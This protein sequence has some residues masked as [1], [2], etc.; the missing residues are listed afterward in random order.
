MALIVHRL[1]IVS[2]SWKAP[3]ST[4]PS[5]NQLEAQ[6]KAHKTLTT[7]MVTTLWSSAKQAIP[8]RR[9]QWTTLNS[10]SQTSRSL[11]IL[12]PCTM[13][14]AKVQCVPLTWRSLK[15][16]RLSN[17]LETRRCQLSFQHQ[18]TWSNS[19]KTSNS[20]SILRPSHPQW[21]N[22][23]TSLT[24]EV[25]RQPNMMSTHALRQLITIRALRTIFLLDPWVKARRSLMEELNSMDHTHLRAWLIFESRIPATHTRQKRN[26]LPIQSSSYAKLRN[27]SRVLIGLKRLKLAI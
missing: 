10:K 20:N 25:P 21:A 5:T 13:E 19:V 2:N 4:N 11:P 23:P 26:H 18:S 15:S 16:K 22:T 7:S 1:A 24:L 14:N 8:P 3:T 17:R 27:C 12:I 9:R 6:M